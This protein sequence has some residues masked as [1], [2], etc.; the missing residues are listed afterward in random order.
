MAERAGAAFAFVLANLAALP[1]LLSPSVS[2]S[3][4]CSVH[5]ANSEVCVFPVWSG[6]VRPPA[7]AAGTD[8]ID[9][10]HRTKK[11]LRPTASGTGL[12]LGEH[13]SIYLSIFFSGRGDDVFGESPGCLKVYNAGPGALLTP[14]P[15]SWS[16]EE[17]QEGRGFLD[18]LGFRVQPRLGF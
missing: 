3:R 9:F 2:R 10:C 16:F 4:F 6:P 17:A 1:P 11:D 14:K 15:T 18:L 13:L 7:A 5:P 12:V 8:Q